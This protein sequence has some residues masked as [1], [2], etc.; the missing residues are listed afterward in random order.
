[1]CR[2]GRRDVSSTLNSFRSIQK[3]SNTFV[4]ASDDVGCWE[5]WVPTICGMLWGPLVG[6]ELFLNNAVFP[7]KC[8]LWVE[9]VCKEPLEWCIV[10]PCQCGEGIFFPTAAQKWTVYTYPWAVTRDAIWIGIKPDSSPIK[11]HACLY[12]NECSGFRILSNWAGYLEG[13]VSISITVQL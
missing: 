1:M 6:L 3:R 10:P 2:R 12:L 9:C 11:I 13:I 4:I 8:W 7:Q 5:D